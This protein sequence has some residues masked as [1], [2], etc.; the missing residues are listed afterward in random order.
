MWFTKFDCMFKMS[1]TVDNANCMFFLRQKFYKVRLDLNSLVLSLHNQGM[2]EY[3]SNTA[4]IY[5]NNNLI[6]LRKLVW[7]FQC[8]RSSNKTHK[9]FKGATLS[10]LLLFIC[11]FVDESGILPVLLCLW[12]ILY[13]VLKTMF[14]YFYIHQLMSSANIMEFNWSEQFAKSFTY[15]KNRRGP[16]FKTCGIPQTIVCKSVFKPSAT[17]MY[18]LLC[19]R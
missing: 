19:F 17:L 2:C 11:N 9:N 6:L 10:I 18:C 1:F 3:K 13:S 5:T 15:S 4:R 7:C 12:K 8:M 16:K 14:L